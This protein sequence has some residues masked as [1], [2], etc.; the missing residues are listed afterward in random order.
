MKPLEAWV[1]EARKRIDEVDVDGDLPELK[2]I[3]ADVNVSVFATTIVP[4]CDSSGSWIIHPA[5]DSS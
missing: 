4:D 2:K 3:I 1:A 5:A